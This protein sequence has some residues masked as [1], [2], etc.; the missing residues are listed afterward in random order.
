LALGARHPLF[1]FHR[2]SVSHG[3]L[4]KENKE[5]S[6]KTKDKVK[7]DFDFQVLRPLASLKTVAVNH[8]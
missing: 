4:N 6:Y 3:R 2:A 8:F 5:I 1:K 7:T